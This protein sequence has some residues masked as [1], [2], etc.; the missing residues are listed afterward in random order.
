MTGR[1]RGVT[2]FGDE[3]FVEALTNGK[4]M[5][6]QKL[7]LPRELAA[8]LIF[9]ALQIVRDKGGEALGRAA[10]SE[11]ALTATVMQRYHVDFAVSA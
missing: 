4:T 7:S 5:A 2:D 8:K 10:L 3:V 9:A 11:E 6:S 1:A